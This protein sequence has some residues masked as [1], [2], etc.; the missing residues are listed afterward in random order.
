M[1]IKTSDL[2]FAWC[3]ANAPNFTPVG[4][5]YKSYGFV[6]TTPGA[7]SALNG[8]RLGDKWIAGKSVMYTF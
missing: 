1:N 6:G 8:P 4:I 2:P 5:G 3:Q 7:W